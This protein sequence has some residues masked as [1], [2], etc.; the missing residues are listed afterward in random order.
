MF[1]TIA[2]VAK[3]IDIA[4]G[5]VV[6]AW[7]GMLLSKLQPPI[8]RQTGTNSAPLAKRGKWLRI[9]CRMGQ[10]SG[11]FRQTEINDFNKLAKRLTQ[12]VMIINA[13]NY[14][15]GKPPALPGDSQCLTFS[16]I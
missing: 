13:I 5:M 12:F 1:F 11:N 9:G 7:K 16:G 14:H 10:K 3:P 8:P 15:L 2:H 4:E 6:P